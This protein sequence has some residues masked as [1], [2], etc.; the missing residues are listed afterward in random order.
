MF[1]FAL[2]AGFVVSPGV[3]TTSVPHM[4][5]VMA[6][7][8][9]IL[10][11]LDP[12]AAKDE[13]R[14]KLLAAISSCRSNLEKSYAEGKFSMNGKPFPRSWWR[15]AQGYLDAGATDATESLLELSSTAKTRVALK[16]G[17]RLMEPGSHFS[18]LGRVVFATPLADGAAESSQ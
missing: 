18:V 13:R 12:A 4:T 9:C 7:A 6:Q 14:A 2:L 16:V 1:A 10:S 5:I 3:Q 17:D 11:N 15:E 8:R